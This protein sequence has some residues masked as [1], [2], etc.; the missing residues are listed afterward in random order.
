L[1]SL[2]TSTL[3]ICESSNSHPGRFNPGT[4]DYEGGWAQ[5]GMDVLEENKYLAPG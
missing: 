4:I 1:L 3:D 5:N 2:S